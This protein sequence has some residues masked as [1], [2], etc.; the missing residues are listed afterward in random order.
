MREWTSASTRMNY[1][2]IINIIIMASIRET[3]WPLA[4]TYPCSPDQVITCR[5]KSSRAETRFHSRNPSP[6]TVA[7][8]LSTV[9]VNVDAEPIGLVILPLSII[10]VTVSMPEFYRPRAL[11]MSVQLE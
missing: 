11:L 10:D 8:V 2:I 4:E 6:L 7:F 9:V 3:L 1:N 5:T